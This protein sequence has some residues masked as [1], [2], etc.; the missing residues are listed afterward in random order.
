VGRK[1]FEGEGSVLK[2]K[3]LVVDDIRII[4]RLVRVNLEL[5]GYEVLEAGNGEE[6][7]R[8]I[9]EK[10]PDLILLDVIMPL[11][12]GFQVLERLRQ[13][14]DTEKIPVIMLTSCSEEVDQIKSWEIGISDYVTK[15]FD[16]AALVAA[17]KRVLDECDCPD[18][19]KKEFSAP[20]SEL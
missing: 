18:G 17:V 16:P 11:V 14:V 15:P 2:A 10:R 3:V 20:R 9:A 13:E 12:D 7:L 6:A 5:E 1:R 19:N 8:V 4:R